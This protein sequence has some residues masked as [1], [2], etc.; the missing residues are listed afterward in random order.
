MDLSH[1][2]GVNLQCQLSRDRILPGHRQYL[3]FASING[4]EFRLRQLA[5][6]R[7][8][9]EAIGA[10]FR[11]THPDVRMSCILDA[12]GTDEFFVFI[13][14]DIVH[15]ITA[16]ECCGPE[17]D[18]QFISRLVVIAKSLASAFGYGDSHQGRHFWRV[19]IV[20]RGVDMPAV[21]ARMRQVILLGDRV[22]VEFPVMRVD[23]F[24]VLEA[25]ILGYET[26]A[27]DLYFRLVG[28]SFEIRM[29]NAPF[30]VES[31]AVAVTL[32]WGI[33]SS[34]EFILGFRR[35]ARLALQDDDVRLVKG[36]M[37]EREF[38][39]CDDVVSP[40]CATD[41]LGFQYLRRRLPI[42][43]VLPS[44]SRKSLHWMP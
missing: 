32:G 27:D 19:E 38:I 15:A 30:G 4:G 43:G 6:I 28:D 2:R 14:E 17:G 35:A 5:I 42:H 33:E 34:G 12:A 22:L 24:D 18:V 3:N 26:V 11:T 10:G 20:Q 13:G 41:I 37:D 44:I 16:D 31:L 25:L 39:V 7:V 9:A 23:E 21:E 40:R 29:K 8:Q 36:I 1:S